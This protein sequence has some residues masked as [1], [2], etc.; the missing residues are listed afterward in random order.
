MAVSAANDAGGGL[1]TLVTGWNKDVLDWKTTRYAGSVVVNPLQVRHPKEAFRSRQFDPKHVEVLKE[2]FASTTST[3]KNVEVV[4]FSP[5]WEA[6]LAKMTY[7]ERVNQTN[8]ELLACIERFGGVLYAISGDHTCSAMR[9]L[10]AEASDDA[11][12]TQVQASLYICSECPETYRFLK[13]LGN[14]NNRGNETFKSMGFPAKLLQF[15][16]NIMDIMRKGDQADM[17]QALSKCKQDLG[18]SMGMNQQSVGSL[19]QLAKQEGEIW[20]LL[21]K[22][23]E[24][25]FVIKNDAVGAA[26]PKGRRAKKKSKKAAEAIIA[27]PLTTGRCFQFLTSLPNQTQLHLLKKVADGEWVIT[28]M[29]KE[30]LRIKAR[31][32]LRG[33]ITEFLKIKVIDHG[34]DLKGAVDGLEGESPDWLAYA[35]TFPFLTAT[36]ATWTETV[37][38]LSAKEEMPADILNSVDAQIA[39]IEARKVIFFPI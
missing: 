36:V 34:Y 13:I 24:G 30:C 38:K 11:V 22:I 20:R 21:W 19:F 2:A 8:D 26:A 31:N 1:A 17:K 7:Q 18:S 14:Q 32:K 28:H 3:P 33:H 27:A 9:E 15:H 29:H 23:V 37:L 10:M 4:L 6:C 5:E 16:T 35:I 39:V 25:G 12:W